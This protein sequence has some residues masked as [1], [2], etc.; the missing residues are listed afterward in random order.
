MENLIVTLDSDEARAI[1]E[2]ADRDHLSRD[3]TSK[4]CIQFHFVVSAL[5][6][7]PWLA[8]ECFLI[9]FSLNR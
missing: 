3:E 9:S 6:L 7:G 8:L 4:V 2:N 1:E 5:F